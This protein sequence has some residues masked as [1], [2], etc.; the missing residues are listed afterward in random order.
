MAIKQQLPKGPGVKRKGSL[1]KLN[2]LEALFRSG[3]AIWE[4]SLVLLQPPA[5]EIRPFGSGR[6]SIQDGE[7]IS[8]VNRT[9]GAV[10]FWELRIVKLVST[11]AQPVYIRNDRPW[12]LR[13]N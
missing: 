10:S 1:R 3:M 12:S 8:I 9:L 5:Q 13:G 4:G 11:N 7:K 6:D 2:P